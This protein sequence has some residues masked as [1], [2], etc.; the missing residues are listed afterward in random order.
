M[1]VL[2]TGATGLV[3]SAIVRE[4]VS[5]DHAVRALVRGSSDLSNLTGATVELARGDILDPPSVAAAVRGCDAV[6]H[7]AGLVGFRPGMR[8]RLLEVNVRGVEIV[9]A[10]ARAAG[11]R[12][13][14]LVSST[15]AAGGSFSPRFADEATPSNAERLGID[16]F[17][18]K[19]RG[20][21]AAHAEARDGLEVVVLR[22][23]Y[24]LGPGDLGRSS[25]ATVL[26]FVTGRLPGYVEGGVSFTD[27]R[28][29]ARAHVAAIER[30]AVR[31]TYFLGGHNLRM[32]E[33]VRRTA[34]LCGLPCP[35]QIPYPV[36]LAAS[37]AGALR[38]RLGGKRWL[39]IDFIRSTSM[40]TFVSSA[41]A[42]R[43]LGYSVRPYEEM[44]RDTLAWWIARGRLEP[45]T[46]ELAAIARQANLVYVRAPAPVPAP[47]ARSASK[48]KRA[49]AVS[50]GVPAPPA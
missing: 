46:P 27:V 36:A 16:Y 40:Y 39:P 3:G 12:R 32:S 42:E 7:A 14:V 48:R 17:V 13:A 9:F 43:E 24:V 15:S 10:A 19:W 35:R 47:K 25:G 11:V 30:E 45:K 37:L 23:G 6:I 18:S 34:A 31:G 22:P 33:A 21:Q 8:E 1:R 2:V 44:T 41:R 4:L 26:Q 5:R 38:E 20:E 29:V 50:N 28:D 49:P